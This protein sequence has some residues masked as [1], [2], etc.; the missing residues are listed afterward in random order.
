MLTGR[1]LVSGYTLLLSGAR[2]EAI[3]DPSDLRCR[4]AR[5][6]DLDGQIL[7]PGFIDVQVNGGGGVSFN[8]DPSPDSIGAIGAAH[9]RCELGG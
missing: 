2:I 9:R 5:N 1:G 6:E 4:D 3:V 8:D 7:L